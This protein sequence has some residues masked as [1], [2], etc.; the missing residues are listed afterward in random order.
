VALTIRDVAAAAGVSTATVSRALRGLE[1]VDPKTRERVVAIARGMNFALSPVASRLASGRTGSIGIVTPY[2]ARW[3]FTEVF[4]GV[5]ETLAPHDVDM[6]L[7]SS[8]NGHSD[9]NPLSAGER[10]RRRVDGVIV[11][12]MSPRTDELE[13][14]AELEVPVVLVG[15]QHPELSSV[16]IDDR[17]GARKA[18]D[19]LLALGHTRIGLI[20]GRP[21]P[22]KFIPEN[23]RFTGYCDALAAEGIGYDDLL[24]VYGMFT[25]P[26]AQ[27]AMAQLLDVSPPVT[28]V[29]CMSDEMAYGA[30][31]TI[32]QRGLR[33]GDD[34]AVI[35][36]D[37]HSLAGVFDLSTV[38][39]PVRELG[40]V[41]SHFL[42]RAVSGREGTTEKVLETVLRPRSS[43]LG[44][45][46]R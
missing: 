35:G 22:T 32:S 24:Q 10:M 37:G 6:L 39:Q 33:V 9:G 28:A 14:L 8:G 3:Y 26:E 42:M 21:L 27:E 1:N 5:E 41:A 11:I 15:A 25:V 40:R 30:M 16:C 44:A 23:D 2:I 12:G 19:H 4:A 7:H 45:A 18:V 43:T 20:G 34:I 29:F 17:L 46:A 31:R 36:F 13:R 38:E